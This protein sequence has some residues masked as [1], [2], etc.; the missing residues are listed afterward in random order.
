ML[1][2]YCFIKKNKI[3]VGGDGLL[4]HVPFIVVS[5]EP[6]VVLPVMM[7]STLL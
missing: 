4:N 7:C 6:E 2:L 5:V 1:R 3:N